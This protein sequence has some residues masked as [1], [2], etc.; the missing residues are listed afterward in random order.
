MGRYPEGHRSESYR[1]YK[2][3]PNNKHTLYLE[4]LFLVINLSLDSILD[5]D[6]SVAMSTDLS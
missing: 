3:D 5:Y 2:E 4:G 6:Y 1:A